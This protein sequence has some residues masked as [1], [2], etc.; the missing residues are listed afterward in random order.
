MSEERVG[1]LREAVGLAPDNHE[2]RRVLAESLAAAG[3]LAEA[4]DQYTVLLDR[5]ALPREHFVAAGRTAL[6]AG[7]LALAGRLVSLARQIGAGAGLPPLQAD[8]EK[9]LRDG[10][11]APGPAVSDI[12]DAAPPDPELEDTTFA[13]VGG[14]EE[15]KKAIHRAIILPFQ[16]PDLYAAYGRRAGGGLMLYGPPGCGKTLLA[17]ATAGECRL[18]FVN[19][20]LED[21]LDPYIGMSEG[22]LHGFFERARALAPCV[23]FLDELDGLAYARRK[24]SGSAGRALVDQLLQELDAIGAD[25]EG[26]LVF[27]AT[28]A[29]WDVDDALKRPGRLDRPVFVPPPGA[30]GRRLILELVFAGRPSSGLDLDALAART[31]LFSGADLAALS[32]GAI[33]LVIE[34][35]L[36]RGGTPPLTMGHVERALERLRPTTRDWLSAARNYVDFANESGL[37]DEVAEFLRTREARDLKG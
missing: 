29:P 28:N 27:G 33:D 31:R 11:P 3:Q 37:Y 17:R 12:A 5:D 4:A 25:N 19:V 9:A 14:L 8:L 32:E 6:D 34:D 1:A 21:V 20:R 22:N 7:D 35:A 26:V 23:L 24:Q 15:A 2:L 16:R 30:E 36:A 10:Q 18:P 13:D